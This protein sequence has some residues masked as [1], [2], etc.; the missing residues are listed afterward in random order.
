MCI[1][2]RCYKQKRGVRGFSRH[3][4]AAERVHP[5]ILQRVPYALSQSNGQCNERF[6]FYTIDR[7]ELPLA[8]G[9]LTKM[10]PETRG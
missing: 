3:H 4:L 2:G 10:V 5:H 6:L 8:I 1:I 7:M 9:G